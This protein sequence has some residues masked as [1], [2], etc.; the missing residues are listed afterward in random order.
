LVVVGFFAVT[1]FFF[2]VED[3][4]V[5]ALDFDD[6]DFLAL[7][8][9]FEALALDFEALAFDLLLRAERAERADLARRLRAERERVY[10][11][12]FH[13]TA[14]SAR[15]DRGMLSIPCSESVTARAAASARSARTSLITFAGRRARAACTRF[16]SS[17]TNISRSGSI[18]SEVPVKP[19]CP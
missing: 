19:V 2:A 12:R 11:G 3:L 7:A 14:R 13:P 9:D 10:S 4:D 8:L 5:L 17:T 16:V 18:Q 6:A 1:A 15:N